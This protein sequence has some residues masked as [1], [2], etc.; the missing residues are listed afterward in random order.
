V[1]VVVLILAVVVALVGLEQE[2]H[3]LLQPIQLTQ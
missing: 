2:L 3:F 1:V